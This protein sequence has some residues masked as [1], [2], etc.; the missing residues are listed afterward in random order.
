MPL[1]GCPQLKSHN[2]RPP[3]RQ[4]LFNAR[5]VLFKIRGSAAEQ[6]EKQAFN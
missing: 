3:P 5:L 1:F 4:E 6:L 2:A